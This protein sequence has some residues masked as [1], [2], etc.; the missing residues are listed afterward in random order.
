M[1][2]LLTTHI[3]DLLLI[4]LLVAIDLRYCVWITSN[5]SFIN[6]LIEHSIRPFNRFSFKSYMLQ[7]DCNLHDY[8]LT[9][10]SSQHFTVPVSDLFHSTGKCV[11][12]H[13]ENQKSSHP[14]RN[15]FPEQ[16][17]FHTL[18][19][20]KILVQF[21][22]WFTRVCLGPWGLQNIRENKT[23]NSD[24]FGRKH[25]KPNRSKSNQKDEIC[26]S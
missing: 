6:L 9:E 7:N 11:P 23:T 26:D 3:I 21:L 12:R 24:E 17:D 25:P 19:V 16:Q 18:G 13:Q 2:V 1:D 4:R 8:N 15:S 5:Y 20:W 22:R 10:R 14:K